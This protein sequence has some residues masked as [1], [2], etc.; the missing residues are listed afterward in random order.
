MAAQMPTPDLNLGPHAMESEPSLCGGQ[1]KLA[2]GS[3]GQ[4]VQP[5]YTLVYDFFYRI[6][7]IVAVNLH[8]AFMFNLHRLPYIEI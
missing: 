5:K 8:Q 6:A 7:A 3:D 2:A 4:R 1:V